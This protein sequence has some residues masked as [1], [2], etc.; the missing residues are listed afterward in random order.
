MIRRLAESMIIA[1]YERHNLQMVVT[2]ADGNY[3]AFKDLIGKA[4]SQR[5][6]KL[7]RET[8]RVLPDLKFFGDLAAHNPLALVRKP[9]LDR[10]H[11]ATRCAIEELSRNI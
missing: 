2:D 6:F 4:T 3:L 8:K 1:A 9:D 5:E 11:A 7:T 10:L